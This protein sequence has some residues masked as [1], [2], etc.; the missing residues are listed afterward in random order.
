MYVPLFTFA[1]PFPDVF[2]GEDADALMIVP[3]RV[4]PEGP[5][6]LETL[7]PSGRLVDSADRAGPQV[8][9]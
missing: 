2:A 8:A 3:Y 6:Q 7:G 9:R 4:G 1:A 5:G